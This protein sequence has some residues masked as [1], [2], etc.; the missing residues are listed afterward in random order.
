MKLENESLLLEFDCKGAEL[1][2]ALNKETQ[3]EL[4]WNG[5][6]AFWGRVSPVLFPIVGKVFNGKYTID[7]QDYQLSQ[8]GFLRD[9]EFEVVRHTENEFVFEFH[10]NDSLL[11]VYPYKH[12]V[13]IAYKLDGKRITVTWHI[14][15]K[16]ENEMFYAIG[17]HPAFLLD[18]EDDY[19]FVFE[20]T[21]NVHQYGLKEG[22]I[23]GKAPVQLDRLEVNE[24]NFKDTTLIYDHT[25]EV[26][27][28]NKN[29]QESVTVA[30]EG[31]DYLALWR[32]CKEGVMAPFVC[33]EPWV[34]IADE[35]GGYPDIREKLGIKRLQK[36][37]DIV[38]QYT[39]TFQ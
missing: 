22:F 19:E 13:Q 11:E 17:A 20:Q 30:Y 2:R 3:K 29:T 34:G 9:Q 28:I 6:A 7:G 1:R 27:L 26:T 10:S 8:H 33:I 25:S 12:K 15:N 36:G 23:D 35:Y 24:A 5:D 31:F 16:D 38:H 39:V 21:E 4:M 18:D 32:P 37:D 14:F